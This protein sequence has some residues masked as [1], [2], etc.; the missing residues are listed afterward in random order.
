MRPSRLSV[1]V[2]TAAV[3]CS[4]AGC[5]PAKATK[6]AQTSPSGTSHAEKAEAVTAAKP[7][8]PVA[9]DDKPAVK[10]D[11]PAAQDEI[12]HAVKDGNTIVVVRTN[13]RRTG[14]LR[15]RTPFRIEAR[16][17][18]S[19]VKKAVIY[20]RGYFKGE[21]VV[22]EESSGSEVLRRGKPGTWQGYFQFNGPAEIDEVRVTM[23]DDADNETPLVSASFPVQLKWK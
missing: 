5:I 14:E 21:E 17:S 20:A 2:V 11:K 23:Y 12:A 22:E 6:P 1:S 9:K 16:Y 4:P 10:D 18:V 7:V 8:V 19:S 3:L 15:R 13:P